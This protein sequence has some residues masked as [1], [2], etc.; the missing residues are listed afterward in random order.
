M[1]IESK[2]R[3]ARRSLREIHEKYTK[4]ILDLEEEFKEK[5]LEEFYKVSL[6]I[7][8]YLEIIENKEE[9]N[10]RIN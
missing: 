4:K 1:N 10:E 3:K 2:V 9:W 8:K 6:D 5:Y 7:D